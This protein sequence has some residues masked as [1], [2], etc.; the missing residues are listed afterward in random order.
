MFE[1]VLG[2]AVQKT[3]EREHPFVI[4]ITGSVGKSTTRQA[5]AALFEAAHVQNVRVSAK[6]YNNELGIPL[7]VFDLPA[8]GRSPWK[9][10]K[11]LWSAFEYGQGLRD[12]GVKY[13]ILEMG[14]D[15]PGDIEHLTRIAP[16]SIGIVTGVTP[17]DPDLVPVHLQQYPSV[18]AVAE[19][20]G[21]LARAV[22]RDGTVIL[23][24]DDP[25]VFA[26][27]HLTHAHAITYGEVEDADI[28]IVSS[29]VYTTEKNG[30]S[31]PAGV[32]VELQAYHKMFTLRVADVFGTSIAYAL[33]AAAAVAEA[34]DLPQ[35][36]LTRIGEHMHPL[37]GRTRILEGRDGIVLFDDSYNASP[38]SMI[39]GLRDLAH[40][41]IQ[42]GGRR[43]AVLGEMRELGER[44]E[45]MHRRVGA[46]AARLGLDYLVVC[47]IFADAYKQG[48]LSAGMS[49][50]CVQVF[51]DTLDTI[52]YLEGMVKSGDI[53]YAKASQGTNHTPGV[54]MERVIK[55]FLAPGVD[56]E[57]VLCRQEPR[58]KHV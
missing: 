4:G 54:R 11:L 18:Q 16:P 15:K 22:P 55:A 28:R 42:A 23:N 50:E 5:V 32:E 40:A 26:M 9:W 7:T 39:A 51:E 1:R 56:S 48:A 6:N 29:K 57:K 20:K 12:T 27:R 30:A 38:A 49:A 36:A 13:A 2:D 43:V 25:R 44:A 37:A 17:V 34:L 24:M 21:M 14:A 8:P 19:Q 35:E 58:W 31:L 47:G 52:P 46:E 33:A 45:E 10:S 53:V 3:I 41:P